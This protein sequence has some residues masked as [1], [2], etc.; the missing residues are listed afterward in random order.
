VLS[1]ARA[2]WASASGSNDELPP[3]ELAFPE[4][5]VDL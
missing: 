5:H 4:F 1:V 3:V 2:E